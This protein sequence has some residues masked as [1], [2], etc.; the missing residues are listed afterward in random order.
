MKK[1]NYINAI[2]EFRED[3]IQTEV[4]FKVGNIDLDDDMHVF[5]YLKS[6]KQMEELAKNGNTEFK[7]LQ[8]WKGCKPKTNP[9][10]YWN[11]DE[12]DD[13][14]NLITKGPII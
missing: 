12:W 6:E 10:E 7:V 11:P 14:F 4:I 5:A 2:V 9:D 3:G 1:R 13:F 8:Y